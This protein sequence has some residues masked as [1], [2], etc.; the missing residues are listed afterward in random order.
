M[1]WA[2][3]YV[4]TISFESPEELR[5]DNT[6]ALLE[7]LLEW[8]QPFL[9]EHGAGVDNMMSHASKNRIQSPAFA[10]ILKVLHILRNFSFLEI[11]ARM[12]AAHVRLKALLI[13]SLLLSSSSDFFD[14]GR[15][16][17]DVLENIAPVVELKNPFDDYIACLANLVYTQDRYLLIGAIRVLT[18]L[19][20]QENNQLY[21]LS[22]L[23][24]IPGRLTALLV[25]NDEELIGT[26]LE[27]LYQFSKISPDFR[28]QL[29]SAHS[30][31]NIGLLVSL[32]TA[33]SKYFCPRVV[34]ERAS[35]GGSPLSV[36]TPTASHSHDTVPCVPNLS[37]YQQ[38]DEPYR[39]LGW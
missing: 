9:D 2:L 13:K 28:F 3:D 16:C 35:S 33:R 39:C 10:H 24:Q 1:E 37:N 19:A 34:R 6:P 32:M 20:T 14:L 38:L 11:N 12:L 17:I 8:A 7:L 31:A 5:L 21:L 36:G 25:A 29:L 15:H 18:M 22:G 4:V 26:V 23:S 30:G 27:Y